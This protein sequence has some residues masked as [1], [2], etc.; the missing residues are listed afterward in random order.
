MGHEKRQMGC[1]LTVRQ[2]F[3]FPKP[4][5]TNEQ[6]LKNHPRGLIRTAMTSKQKWNPKWL[7]RWK[8]LAQSIRSS[9]ENT[10]QVMLQDRFKFAYHTAPHEENGFD[11]LIAK[12]GPK[13]NEPGAKTADGEDAFGGGMSVRGSNGV[14]EWDGHATDIGSMLGQLQYGLGRPVFDKTGLTGRYDF[15]LKFV[16]ERGAASADMSPLDAPPALN[17][18]LQE[19]L[20]LRLVPRQGHSR[21][22]CDRP[23]RALV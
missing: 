11:L 7:R 13:F 3:S 19:Q 16:S 15:T 14:A 10:L 20:G 9:L 17:T 8:S 12:N 1:W 18:A 2:V 22:H 5:G 6:E 4:F 23:Y 21:V